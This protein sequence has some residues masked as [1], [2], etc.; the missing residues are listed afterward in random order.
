[1][2]INAISY[3]IEQHSSDPSNFKTNSM[4]K[5][6]LSLIAIMFLFSAIF[7]P[8]S[9]QNLTEKAKGE[10]SETL[11]LWNTAAKNS[12]TDQL[13]SLFDDSEN[14]MLIGSNKGEIW[15]GKDQIKGHLISIFPQESVSW[16]MTRIDIDGNN[17]TAWVFVDGAIII[18]DKKGEPMKAPYRFTGIMVK[19]DKVWKWRLFDGSMPDEE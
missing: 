11:K 9:A 10:I 19:I 17:N 14:I 1:M 7:F 12:D 4:K 18:S 2:N 5:N 15:K 3:V 13:M 6:V 16:E 8:L